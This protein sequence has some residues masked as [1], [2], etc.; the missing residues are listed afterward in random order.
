M[1]LDSKAFDND[2]L[3]Y[4]V[5]INVDKEGGQVQPALGLSLLGRS[6]F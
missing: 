4:W 3:S 1:R 5:V 2:C 6:H